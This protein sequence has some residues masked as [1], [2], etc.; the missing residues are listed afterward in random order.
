M[1]KIMPQL[2]VIS[3]LGLFVFIYFIPQIFITIDS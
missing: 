2:I 3:L 1:R